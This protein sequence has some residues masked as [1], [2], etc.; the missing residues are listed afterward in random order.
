MIRSAYFTAD[1]LDNIAMRM[2]HRLCRE[3]RI[4]PVLSDIR[5]IALLVLD[6]QQCFLSSDSHAFIPSAPAI[7]PGINALIE[8]FHSAGCPVILTRHTNTPADAGLML[9]RWRHLIEPDDAASRIDETIHVSRGVVMEK[10]RYDA[11]LGTPL[12]D[13]LA[14]LMITDIVITGV[15]THICCDATAR[16]AFQHGYRVFFAIDGTATYTRRLHEASLLTLGHCCVTPIRLSVI[17]SAI[18]EVP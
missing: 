18:Q 7:V 3:I 11:F 16:S 6:M 4:D 9:S 2:E 15:M 12:A 17:A 8:R 1:T 5:R 14:A 13:R 10:H